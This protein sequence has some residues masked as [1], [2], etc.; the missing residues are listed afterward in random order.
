M[1]DILARLC[2]SPIK[3]VERVGFE[4]LDDDDAIEITLAS[5]AILHVDIG[6]EHATDVVLYA[7]PAFSRYYD[8]LLE[9]EPLTFTESLEQWRRAPAEGAQWLIGKRLSAPRRLDMT[10]PYHA[11]VGYAFDVHGQTLALFGIDDL[12][13]IG[14]FDDPGLARFALKIE[15]RQP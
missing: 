10:E 13:L 3:L 4:P 7:G 1:S 15:A 2:S 11:T 9:E 5:G 8:H 14:A 6:L 12:I